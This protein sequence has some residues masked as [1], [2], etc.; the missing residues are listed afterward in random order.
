[1]QRLDIKGVN[2]V[3]KE[4]KGRV[5]RLSKKGMKAGCRC[6]KDT[7]DARLGMKDTKAGHK[8]CEEDTKAGCKGHE[9]CG[10]PLT[11]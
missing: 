8:G 9:G 7:K 10:G 4:C 2:I 3:P 6:V 1:M 5:Q 11:D